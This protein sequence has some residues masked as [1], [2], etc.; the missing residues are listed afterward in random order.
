M[1]IEK[2]YLSDTIFVHDGN[3]LAVRALEAIFLKK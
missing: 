3:R 2:Q 1:E